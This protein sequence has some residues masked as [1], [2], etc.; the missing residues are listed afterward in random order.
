ML[1]YVLEYKSKSHDFDLFRREKYTNIP[2][3]KRVITCQI[4]VRCISQ[5]FSG[6]TGSS[7]E[8][9]INSCGNDISC[10][11]KCVNEFKCQVMFPLFIVPFYNINNT[12]I[13]I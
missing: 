3:R 13:L 2:E 7:L 9:C 12:Y 1:K 10:E 8:Q 5:R 6:E 11:T 4:A